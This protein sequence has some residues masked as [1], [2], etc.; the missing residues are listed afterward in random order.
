MLLAARG[1]LKACFPGSG[2]RPR[3]VSPRRLDLLRAGARWALLDDLEKPN[4]FH[5][6]QPPLRPPLQGLDAQYNFGTKPRLG[7]KQ[8]EFLGT[9]RRGRC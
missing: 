3:G 7:D 2:K 5:I 6:I 8:V 1:L 9:L 4:P